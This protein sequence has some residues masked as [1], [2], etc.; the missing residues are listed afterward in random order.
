MPNMYEYFVAQGLNLT[1]NTGFFS[2]IVPDRLGFNNQFVYLRR[3]ILTEARIISLVYKVPFPGVTAD[4]L[5]FVLEK[6]KARPNSNVE[7][8]EYRKPVVRRSQTELL[9]HPI[10]AFEHFENSEVMQLIAKVSSSYGSTRIENICESTSGFG[11]KSQLIQESK[12]SA[13]QVPTLKGDSI[14]RYEIRKGYWFDFRRENITGR[15]TDK[16]KLGASP[17]ILLRKTGDRIIATYDDTG[18]FPEQSLYFLFGNRSEMDFKFLLGVLNSRLMTTY[19]RAKSLTN[20]RSIAQVKKVDLDQLPIPMLSL[21]DCQDKACYDKMVSLVE[22]M[23]D[24]PKDLKSAKA[25]DDKTRLQRQI[26]A[27]DKQIDQLVYELYG[28]TEEEIKVV[29]GASQ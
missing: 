11:G 3:R 22:R 7:I 9:R 4:T 27:T 13:K 26:D 5:I 1:H 15:T 10:H 23:L 20:R 28:L 14:G 19:Y 16:E 8:S 24:L 17:K 21:S 25:P 18:I 12:T 29:E 6:G 2:F